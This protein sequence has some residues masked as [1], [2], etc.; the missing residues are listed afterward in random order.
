[1]APFVARLD[2]LAT[3]HEGMACKRARDI[4][5]EDKQASLKMD[6]LEQNGNLSGCVS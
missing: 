2:K 4:E 1:M 3:V 6:H 5:Q